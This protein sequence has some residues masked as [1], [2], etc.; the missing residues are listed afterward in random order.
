VKEAGGPFNGQ[1]LMGIAVREYME[2]LA[3][4]VVFLILEPLKSTDLM[5][6]YKVRPFVHTNGKLPIPISDA[7]SFGPTL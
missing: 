5:S 2:E 1:D 3:I 4:Y 6:Q 7:R